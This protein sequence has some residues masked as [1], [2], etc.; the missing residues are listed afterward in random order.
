[1]D[2]LRRKFSKI[3]ENRRVFLIKNDLA[4]CNELLFYSISKNQPHTS[5]HQYST[6]NFDEDFNKKHRKEIYNLTNKGLQA[7]LSNLMLHLEAVAEQ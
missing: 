2:D 1:M 5:L 7:R 4:T 3:K 6:L